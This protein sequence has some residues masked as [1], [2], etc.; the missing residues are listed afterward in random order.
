M[1]DAA[2]R[3]A[4]HGHANGN[5]D[6]QE[7]P[8]IDAAATQEFAAWTDYLAGLSREPSEPL[9]PSISAALAP[10][11]MEEVTRWYVVLRGVRRLTEVAGL[12]EH[13]SR[14]PPCIAVRVVDLSSREVCILVTATPRIEQAGLEEQVR[15]GLREVVS[16]A[17]FEVVRVTPQQAG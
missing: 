12:R 17:T 14:L 6:L 4:P 1:R 11:A 8:E 13:L 9:V 5:G 7:W 16:A 15:N 2:D 3:G 10:A